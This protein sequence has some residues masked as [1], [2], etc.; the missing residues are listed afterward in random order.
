MVVGT[1]LPIPYT[2]IS[3]S[4]NGDLT[5]DIINIKL[6]LTT[7]CTFDSDVIEVVML[8]DGDVAG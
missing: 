7:S 4:G 2:V 1:T 5:R 8:T 6:L 3:R